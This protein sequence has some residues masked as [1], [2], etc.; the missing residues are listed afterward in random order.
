MPH[1]GVPLAWERAL[2]AAFI[3]GPEYG[4][5][6]SSVMRFDAEGGVEFEERR[7]GPNAEFAGESRFSL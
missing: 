2:S 5:R 6:A 4:T 7:L 1:T 3:D